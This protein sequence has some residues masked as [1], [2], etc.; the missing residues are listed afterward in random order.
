MYEILLSYQTN[1]VAHITLSTDIMVFLM[2][3]NL[4]PIS[5]GTTTMIHPAEVFD[6]KIFRGDLHSCYFLDFT[7]VTTGM[8]LKEI[9]LD[10]CNTY[11]NPVQSFK[12]MRVLVRDIV[13]YTTAVL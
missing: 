12:Y 1:F 10:L 9:E 2:N 5:Y 6:M 4:L 13:A 7:G 8:N 3:I 11:R